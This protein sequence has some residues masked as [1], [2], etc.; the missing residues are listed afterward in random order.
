MEDV[1][2]QK[3]YLKSV[4]ESLQK[5]QIAESI[6]KI[7]NVKKVEKGKWI[8][9]VEFEEALGLGVVEFEEQELLA[10]NQLR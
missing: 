3:N 10:L 7:V 1:E 5:K 4:I 9:Y 6:A 2:I 8:F